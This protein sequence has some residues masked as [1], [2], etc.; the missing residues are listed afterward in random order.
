M[1][2][3]QRTALLTAKALADAITAVVNE[4]PEGAP[5][6]AMYAA[7]LAFISVD[8]FRRLMDLLVEAGRVRRGRGHVYFPIQPQPVQ[9]PRR[10]Q[11]R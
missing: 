6:G 1:T 8:D 9:R 2:H 5:A 4:T 3:E 7:L 11:R 10:R